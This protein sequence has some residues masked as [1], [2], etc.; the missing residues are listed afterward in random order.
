LHGRLS[1][2]ERYWQQAPAGVRAEWGAHGA[3]VFAELGLSVVVVDVLSFSTAVD[4]AVARGIEVV[5]CAP[6][7]DAADLAARG[8]ATLASPRGGSAWSLSPAALAQAPLIQRLVLPSA[9][10]SA[11]SAVAGKGGAKVIAACLRNAAAVADWLLWRGLACPE[12]PVGI[13]PAGERWP[14][15]SLRPAVEDALGAGALAAALARRGASLSAEAASLAGLHSATPDIG[16]ALRDC[17]SGR[18]LIAGHHAADVEIAA[19]P[20]ASAVVPLLRGGAFS[21]AR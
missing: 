12:R 8:G 19:Q 18:E 16:T 2:I 13:V 15:G 14:D 21:A 5:P 1:T 4:V 10:G 20:D 7:D 11:L 9:N 17:A 3:R 6:D